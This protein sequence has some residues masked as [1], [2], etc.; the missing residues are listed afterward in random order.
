ML[1]PQYQQTGKK[2]NN[3]LH[4]S[5][6]DLQRIVEEPIDFSLHIVFTALQFLID[7][8]FCTFLVLADSTVARDG[9]GWR[10]LGHAFTLFG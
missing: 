4:E 9:S 3:D 8:L 6:Y 10:W 5:L 1:E 2:E 7:F